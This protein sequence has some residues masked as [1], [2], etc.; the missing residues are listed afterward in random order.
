MVLKGS[1][2]FHLT[3]QDDPHPQSLE[4]ELRRTVGNPD[5]SLDVQDTWVQTLTL[6]PNP[7]PVLN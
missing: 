6:T 2:K 3:H 7:N 5:R 4:L 1:P